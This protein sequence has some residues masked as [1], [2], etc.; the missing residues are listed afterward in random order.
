MKERAVNADVTFAMSGGSGR[1][2]G[3][4]TSTLAS[5][6]RGS[7]RAA[8]TQ[9]RAKMDTQAKELAEFQKQVAIKYR[10]KAP[11]TLPV[12]KGTRIS[13]RLRG[14]VG[15]EEWQPMPDEWLEGSGSPAPTKA[16]KPS[17]KTGLESDDESALTSLSDEE[18]EQE[19]P[20]IAEDDDDREPPHNDEEDSTV[21]G[22]NGDVKSVSEVPDDFVEWETV[23][24]SQH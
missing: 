23:C 6:G 19:P 18:E 21:N 7:G 13:K 2:N 17:P 15:E 20:V 11:A 12:P 3:V 22:F 5:S 10:G 16:R 4:Q 9:A 8:K 1:Q 24:L 14:A